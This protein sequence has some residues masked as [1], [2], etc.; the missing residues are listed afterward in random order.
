MEV[1]LQLSQGAAAFDNHTGSVAMRFPPFPALCRASSP[2]LR[3]EAVG[4]FSIYGANYTRRSP[5]AMSG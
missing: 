1:T 3:D 5:N 2:A 4:S